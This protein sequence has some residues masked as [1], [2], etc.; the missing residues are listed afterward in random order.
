MRKRNPDIIKFLFSEKSQTIHR[1]TYFENDFMFFCLYYFPREFLHPLA[2]FQ[3]EYMEDLEK[4]KNV[5]FVWF[6]ECGKSMILT[7]YYVWVLVF[8]KKRFVMHYNSEI[9]QSKSML[10]DVIMILQENELIIHDFWFLYLPDEVR[11]RKDKKQK[12][13]S[14]FITENWIKMKAMSIWK[15][16]RW[17]KFSYDW[18]TYRPDLICFDDLDT[19][20][21]TKTVEKIEEDFIF[22]TW[23]VFGWV[24]SYS[25]IIFLWN[26]INDI[27]RVPRLKE[28]FEADEKAW[29]KVFWVPI[30][31]RWQIVWDRF[32]ATDQEAQEK[33][34]N[35]KDPR[36]YFI[37]LEEKK[38][39]Q[40]TIWYNQ[41]FNLIPYKK[42]Q[43]IISDWYIKYYQN[44][45][46]NYKVAIWIDPAFSE[47]TNSDK[48]WITVTAQEKFNNINY[49]YV[50]QSISLDGAEKNYLNFLSV[51]RELYN[52]Y[53]A[54]R[55]I[56]EWNNWWEI[57]WRMLR[58]DGLAVQIKTAIKDKVTRLM[59]YQW[60]FERWLIRFNPENSMV[61]ELLAQLREFPIIDH[62]DM[63]DSMVYSFS[64]I[65]GLVKVI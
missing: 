8:R 34:K 36:W 9:E 46:K 1:K 53:K 43:K 10:R 38:R 52:K 22:I 5:F 17:A 4:S 13:I 31:Q 64:P 49:F 54:S 48:I 23:E 65:S 2:D 32:V 18:V 19:Q 47:K 15:S 14:E 63:V 35:I 50:I 7:L 44:L 45:P 41:N 28:H 20:K 40:G 60:A 37:S 6:R 42:W 30:R 56:I 29:V 26:V 55:I 59:E 21:N 11:S 51:V 27:W 58:N 16:P 3:K 61:W 39:K 57:L 24:A 33:N 12:T 25:Q 62:D